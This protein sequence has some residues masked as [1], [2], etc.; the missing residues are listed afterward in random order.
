MAWIRRSSNNWARC[1]SSFSLASSMLSSFFPNS[2]DFR[3]ACNRTENINREKGHN[4]VYYLPWE[5]DHEGTW[6]S[7]SL[8]PYSS[9]TWHPLY[10]PADLKHIKILRKCFL[11]N[12][13]CK[14]KRTSFV[15]MFDW[16]SIARHGSKTL[17]HFFSHSRSRAFSPM[18][19]KFRL[20]KEVTLKVWF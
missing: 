8:L 20:E 13:S 18:P 16:I 7:S 12:Y 4:S 11:L 14:K 9:V 6:A 1:P 10:D 2:F 15:L 5:I 3:M 17:L 19:V